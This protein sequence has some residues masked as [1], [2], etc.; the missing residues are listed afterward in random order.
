MLDSL[1][2]GV[3]K[4]LGWLFGRL[5]PEAAV[6]IGERLGGLAHRLQP[7]RVQIGLN[8]LRAAYGASL[9]PEEADA[10]IRRLFRNFGACFVE[11]LRMDAIDKAYIDRYLKV[12]GRERFDAAVAT[13]RPVI[14]LTGHFGNWEL[15][16]ILAALEGFPILALAR[17]QEKFPKLY[18]LLVAS[19]ESKGC[20]VVHKG[21][22]MRQLL[23]ALRR[24]ELIGIV[25]DQAARKGRPIEFYGRTAFFATGPFELARATNALILPGFVHR[26]RGPFHR[27]V[28]EPTIDMATLGEGEAQL[29]AGQERFARVLRANIDA[30]PAL[31]LWLHKRWKH[32]P[33]RR[34]VVL[35][36]GKRGHVKQSLAVV[37]AMTQV[38]EGVAHEVLEVRYRRFGR[39]LAMALAWLAPGWGASRGLRWT[40]TAPAWRQIGAAYA[41][42]V[43]STGS[44]TAPINRLLT[45]RL[46]AKSVVVM[47]P[48][49]LPATAFDL[50]F[51]PAHDRPPRHPRVIETPGALSLI[52]A[53]TVAQ[54]RQALTR[55][56]RFRGAGMGTEMEPGAGAGTGAAVAPD[57]GDR[58][59][60]DG[61][62]RRP[63]VAVFLGGDTPEYTLPAE[64]AEALARQ[65]LDACEALDARCLV[66]GS[67][68]TP[69]PAERRL[70]ALL[71]AHPRCAL[72]LR[73]SRDHLNGTLE[74]MLGW[75]TVTVV[76]GE[77]ISMVSEACAAGGPVLVVEPPLRDRS[78]RGQT[79]GRPEARSG[80]RTKAQR[81]LSTLEARGLARRVDVDA[82]GAAIREAVAAQSVDAV[83]SAGTGAGADS[84]ASIATRDA[85][86]ATVREAVARLLR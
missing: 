47:T 21:G 19:R 52:D 39:P 10:I 17:E 23:Q 49:P 51:I 75:A 79:S 16:S 50:S 66:T 64:W 13:G 22:A 9:S 86:A 42:V 57:A 85:M 84:A 40:L 70:D 33:A 71:D 4:A 41:D 26:V 18:R 6:A 20:R 36:D 58:A 43:V 48:A 3:V 12:E 77:S 28:I 74:G 27:V 35:S 31:W 38:R 62:A 11:L 1:L 29:R 46:R 63:V 65:V 25:G 37:R 59:D 30:D 81:F 24:R 69:E 55:H 72:W 82:L 14:L 76:T 15:T 53:A 78:A 2:C 45:R 54:E 5:S 83:R 32:T 44:S 80:T 8:N 67:R 60:A 61:L 7:K 34:V 68:R 73:A 56:A